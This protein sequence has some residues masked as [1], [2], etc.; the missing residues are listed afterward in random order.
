MNFAKVLLAICLLSGIGVLQCVQAATL[1]KD[2]KAVAVVVVPPDSDEHEKL[3]VQDLVTYVE[4]ISGAKLEVAP[5][6]AA[7][8]AAF[9]NQLK[10]QGKTPVLLGRNAF[11]GREVAAD[12]NIRGSFTLESDKDSVL[13]A[14][15][16]E[17]TYY[18]VLELLEQQGVRFFMPGD[19]GTVIPEFKTIEVR[20]QKTYQ[21]PSFPSRWYQEPDLQWQKRVR[22]GGEI[23]GGGHGIKAPPYALN[24][25]TGKYE[26]EANAEYYGLVNGQRVPRQHCVSNP[27]LIEYSANYIIEQRRKTGRNVFPLGPNDGSGMCECPNCR[28]LDTGDYDAFSGELS[29]TDRYIW[30]FNRVL[31]KVHAEFPDVKVAF[32]VYHTYMRPPLREKPNPAIQGALAPIGLDRIHGFSNPIAPEKGY[33]KW[34]FQ[35]WGKLL[36]ELYDRGYWSNL[37]DPGVTFIINSRLRDEIP[38]CYDM[39]VKG[40]RTQTFPNYASQF[41][42]MYLAGKLMWNHKLDVDALLQDTYDKFFGPASRPMGEYIT[43]MDA[44][45]RDGDYTTGSAWDIPHFYPPTLRTRARALLDE[46]AQRANGKGVYADRVKLITQTFDMTEAFCKMLEAR[47]RLDLV[48]AK[49]ELDKCD[50]VAAELM[51]YDPPMLSKGRFSTYDQYMRRFFRH[52]SEQGA[53]RVTNGNQLVAAARDEWQFQIDPL[54]VGEDIGLWRSDITGGGWQPLKTSSQSWSNQGLRYY[55]GLAWYRQEVDVPANFVGKRIFLWCGGVDE[56]AKVWVN[57]KVIGISSGAAIYPFEMDATAAI[58]P[59]KNVITMCVANQR[60]NEIGTGGI[61][62]PVILYAPAKGAGATLE[63]IRDLKPTFP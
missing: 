8:V 16:Y 30:F 56:T 4:K 22:C 19:L 54:K 42:G 32:Y 12:L 31:E 44:A 26:P 34:L 43:L 3:A 5:V 23:F 40:W 58:K 7:D 20:E 62:A 50:A 33:A 59:G 38:A 48:A 63:N 57:G 47:N 25:Q 15:P 61:L 53:A 28:A 6:K 9:A 11:I 29:V 18:G 39:G 60:V 27:K 13:I 14:G 36:P 35:E 41:P 52:A 2:G 46:G 21:A 51:A 17:G 24:K 55:R 1:V 49:T 45:L 37:S 10:Q